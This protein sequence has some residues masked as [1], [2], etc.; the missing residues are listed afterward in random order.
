MCRRAGAFPAVLYKRKR[1]LH[2]GRRTEICSKL[3]TDGKNAM[4]AENI[5]D[6]RSTSTEVLRKALARHYFGNSWAK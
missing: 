1:V 4:K 3:L 2:F 5:R 6:V